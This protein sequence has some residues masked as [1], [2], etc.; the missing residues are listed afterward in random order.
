MFDLDKT[1]DSQKVEDKWYARWLEKQALPDGLQI[2]RTSGHVPGHISVIV[3][4]ADLPTIIAGDALLTRD[5]DEGILTMI[6]QNR[7]Q[8]QRDRALILSLPG[9]IIPG[10]DRPF[11]NKPG[12]GAHPARS[13]PLP[14]D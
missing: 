2:L 5:H 10:H 11:L 1:Y 12:P 8:A 4:Q 13:A 7:E 9:H 14:Q 3:D 6:A